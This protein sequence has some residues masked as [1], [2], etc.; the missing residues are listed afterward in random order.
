[1]AQTKVTYQG[2]GSTRTFSVP[3]PYLSTTHVR[4][5]VNETPLEFGLEWELSTPSTVQFL[6]NAPGDGDLVK[7]YRETAIDQREVD[8]QNGA[9]LTE[10]ELDRDS[11]Q[12][13]YLLQETVENYSDLVN[14]A[15]TDLA[16]N[17]GVIPVEPDQIIGQLVNTVLNSQLAAS[18]QQRITDI[19]TNAANVLA[20]LQAVNQEILDRVAGDTSLQAQI[21]G[22][23]TGAAQSVFV[24]GEE[25]EAG[26]NGIPN[27]IPTFARW[28]DS[29]NGYKPHIWDSVGD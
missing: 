17:N 26:V 19:D 9:V 1:M 23:N 15:L 28:Y 6:I 29:D 8:Y 27:P 25:P 14:N 22:I 11:L 5:A 3:F 24:Q 18:L 2:N 20:A 16:T 12:A 10:E 4:V 7:I 13:F 21:D